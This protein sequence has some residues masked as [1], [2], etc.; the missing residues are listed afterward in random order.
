MLIPETTKREILVNPCL[1]NPAALVQTSKYFSFRARLAGWA[2]TTVCLY[3]GLLSPVECH[4]SVF[5]RPKM[6]AE[7]A[8]EG[9][10]SR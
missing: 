7:R 5:E 1:H 9:L 10:E 6:P 3:V 4:V 8:Q 2:W